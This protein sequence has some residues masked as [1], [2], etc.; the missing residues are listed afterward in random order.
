MSNE[1]NRTHTPTAGR[2]LAGRI[3]TAL[4]ITVATLATIGTAPSAAMS[5]ATA[6]MTAAGDLIITGT[7]ANDEIRVLDEGIIEVYDG[8]TQIGQWPDEDFKRDLIINLGNGADQ[9]VLDE[10]H[11]HRD[12]RVN[13]GNGNDIFSGE[14]LIVDRNFRYSQGN[15]KHFFGMERSVVNGATTINLGTGGDKVETNLNDWKGNFSI[16]SSPAGLLNL[17]ADNDD[18]DRTYRLR[19]SNND[20]RVRFLNDSNFDGTTTI[21]LRSGDDQLTIGIGV[22]F[23]SRITARLGA[24]HDETSVKS[25][26][27]RH[28]VNFDLGSGND[29]IGLD[30]ASFARRSVFNGGSGSD[31][32]TYIGTVSPL[33]VFRNI[34]TQ[35]A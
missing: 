1:L 20:D 9:I 12:F 16:A 3:I 13:N 4:L 2:M 15:G 25:A 19:G 6:R 21:D 34:E 23:Y 8:S 27:F 31:A 35:G 11:V 26:T 17:T 5:G 32:S 22:H 14:Q 28:L 10:V 18:Y 7:A 33:V 29:W 30:N 24:G